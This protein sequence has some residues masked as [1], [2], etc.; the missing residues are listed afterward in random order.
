MKLFQKINITK[1]KKGLLVI[2]LMTSLVFGPIYAQPAQAAWGEFPQQIFKTVLEFIKTNIM[3]IVVSALKTAAIKAINQEMN[4]VIGGS[5]SSA[6]AFITDWK[7]YLH[8]KP[9]ENADK[10][11]NDYLSQTV[12]AGRASASG[13]VKKVGSSLFASNYEGVGN[14]SFGYGMAMNNSSFGKF[15]YMAQASNLAGAEPSSTDAAAS[16]ETAEANTTGKTP[17]TLAKC[18]QGD[19]NDAR[20]GYANLRLYL[21]GICNSW[22]FNANATMAYQTKLAEEKQTAQV[23][24]TASQGFPGTKKDG[25]T[26]SP[27]IL[28]KDAMANVQNIGSTALATAQDIKGVVTGLVQQMITSAIQKGIGKASEVVQKKVQ[29][30]KAKATTK[31][32][33]TAKTQGVGSIFKNQ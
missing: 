30:T 10:Y 27:G 15:S 18:T 14:G 23:E 5:F 24:G 29:D 1:F 25:L 2:L 16:K 22:G 31:V 21:S 20:G 32:N 26:V 4:S 8:D 28:V 7:D 11:M 19:I 9:R 6:P 13:Y 33:E 12:T 17:P 3:S